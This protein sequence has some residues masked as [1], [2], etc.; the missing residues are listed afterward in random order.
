MLDMCFP[1]QLGTRLMRLCYQG[2]YK[3][4]GI[5][6]IFCSTA[7]FGKVAAAKGRS[8]DVCIPVQC[9]S[10]LNWVV[11]QLHISTHNQ[12]IF[13]TL[14]THSIIGCSGSVNA[15][16]ALWQFCKAVRSDNLR[17]PVEDQASL[18]SQCGP[19]SRRMRQREHIRCW[20]RKL[21]APKRFG[22]VGCLNQQD[23][24][25]T[26]TYRLYIYT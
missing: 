14:S 23:V 20:S 10:W 18:R 25:C 22:P 13:N 11:K 2:P 5:R 1:R 16:E 6:G 21:P 24:T 19:G 9:E 12:R 4:P 26:H 3:V 7:G 15:N 17:C 8:H